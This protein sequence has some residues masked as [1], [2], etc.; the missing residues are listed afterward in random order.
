LPR[1]CFISHA[2]A[3]E[4]S[5]KE[6]LL[7]LPEYVSPLVF[8]AIEVRPDQRVSDD[9]IEAI[10]DCPG[11]IYLESE[12]SS[13]SFWVNFEKDY[14]LRARR[15]VYGYDAASHR[16]TRDS[17]PPKSLRVFQSYARHDR[18]VVEEIS[19]VMKRRY[20]SVWLDLEQLGTPAVDEI[21]RGLSETLK[22]G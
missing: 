2:Y 7:Q 21:E 8:P 1:R 9:L 19:A 10:L 18:G 6:L 17:S 22:Q 11:L 20:F 14:A 12:K 16:L 13:K 5:L 4:E 15:R 3:D